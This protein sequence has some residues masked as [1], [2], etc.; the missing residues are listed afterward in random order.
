[1]VQKWHENRK[2]MKKYKSKLPECISVPQEGGMDNPK[3][4]SHSTALH[5]VDQQQ[6]STTACY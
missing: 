2:Y 5:E 1:M 4:K 6:T 3:S